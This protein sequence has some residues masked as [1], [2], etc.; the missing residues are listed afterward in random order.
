MASGAWLDVDSDLWL[1]AATSVI[2]VPHLEELRLAGFANRRDS[3]EGVDQSL[4]L[5]A[6]LLSRNKGSDPVVVVSG[7]LLYFGTELR[8]TAQAWLCEHGLD[9]SRILLFA[10]HTHNAPSTDHSKP[11]LGAV[12]RRFVSYL[13]SVI[14]A[15][16]MEA[17]RKLPVRTHL[18]HTRVRAAHALH[19]RR[20]KWHFER[21]SPFVWSEAYMGPNPLF[22][23]RDHIDVVLFESVDAEPLGC[24]WSYACHPSAYPRKG[25]V[26]ADYVGVV[27]EA[28]RRR[29]GVGVPIIFGQ[30]AAGD[31]RPDTRTNRPSLLRRIRT[32]N[33]EQRF[34]PFSISAWRTW[35]GGLAQLLTSMLDRSE[36]WSR[37][38]PSLE[39][40]ET[41]VAVSELIDGSVPEGSDLRLVA[42]QL[43]DTFRLLAMSAEPVAKYRNIFAAG[44]ARAHLVVGCEG[45]VFGYLPTERMLN[46]GGYEVNRFF[47]YFGLHGSFRPGFE[48]KVT[49]AGRHALRQVAESRKSSKR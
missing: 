31:V 1:Q 12:D 34:A 41:T 21:Q 48:T 47:P 2:D 35:S 45:A 15:L 24:L 8:D 29:L 44:D 14:T 26:H 28:L 5:N 46:E 3:P 7:D 25:F 16:I 19:R 36:C 40:A 30:G 10:S 18:R 17:R 27:R 13:A 6:L 43:A 38:E 37:L 11:K 49:Q 20:L 39:F 22:R 4:E 9:P 23:L 33:E 42:L 32:F